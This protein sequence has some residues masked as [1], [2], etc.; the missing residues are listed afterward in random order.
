[1]QTITI[2]P[3]AIPNIRNVV[4][5][6]IAAIIL[7]PAVPSSIPPK[8][9]PMRETPDTNPCRSGNHFTTVLMTTLYPSPT[10]RPHKKPYVIYIPI[11]VLM[12]EANMNP[13]ASDTAQRTIVSLYPFFAVMI[14]LKNPPIQN[15]IIE[16]ENVTDSC[17]GLHP[18]SSASGALNTL[19][20]YINPRN[21][22]KTT[23]SAR[24]IH[25]IFFNFSRLAS[26]VVSYSPSHF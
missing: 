2:M 13:A 17:E 15:I 16:I 6:P 12:R 5:H 14:P 19:H 18:N 20:A 11:R 26:I 7:A 24:Y 8:P 3:N 1:M 25:L 4:L 21:S 23:P 10:P 22:S 9:N